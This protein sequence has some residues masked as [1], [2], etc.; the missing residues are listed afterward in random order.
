MKETRLIAVSC[1]VGSLLVYSALADAQRQSQPLP[2]ASVNNENPAD[3]V[4]RQARELAD[5]FW[6]H[7]LLQCGDSHWFA[8]R[9]YNGTDTKVFQIKGTPSIYAK[10]G[11]HAPR[12]LSRAEQMNGVDP[13]PIE[14]DGSMVLTFT[15]GAVGR[16]ANCIAHDWQDG[17]EYSIGIQKRKGVWEF[18]QGGAFYHSIHKPACVGAEVRSG[19]QYLSP[20]MFDGRLGLELDVYCRTKYGDSTTVTYTEGAASGWNCAITGGV[21]KPIDMNDACQWQYSANFRAVS[22]DPSNHKSWR[23]APN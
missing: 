12:T 8:N 4:Y 22:D 3:A 11:Y 5:A 13:Q 17:F 6:S 15:A 20:K 7:R 1:L 9:Y 23:C 2:R 19:D 10:G 21:N 16:C 18:Q 14:Y